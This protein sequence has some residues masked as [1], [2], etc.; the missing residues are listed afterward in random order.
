MRTRNIDNNQDAKDVINYALAALQHATR[1]AVNH[2]MK[3]SPGEIVFRRDMFIDVPV[4]VDLETIQQRRQALIDQNLMR[5]NQK[6]YDYH[7]QVNDYVMV[8]KYDPKK[9]E[10]RVHGP[11]QITECRTNGTVQIQRENPMIQETFNIRKLVPYRGPQVQ[12]QNDDQMNFFQQQA[13][14][15]ITKF[16]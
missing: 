12:A 1:C 11:Y 13:R 15:V 2:T 5:I 8:K 7:Y 3:N 9:G 14:I 4:L 16:V 6:R 10:E